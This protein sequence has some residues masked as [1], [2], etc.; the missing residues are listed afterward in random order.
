VEKSRYSDVIPLDGASY[1]I[2]RTLTI[3]LLADEQH[4]N[5]V[6]PIIVKMKP[7]TQFSSLQFMLQYVGGDDYQDMWNDAVEQLTL[8]YL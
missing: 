2:V 8:A 6:L 1:N 7:K 3:G 4:G 5:A